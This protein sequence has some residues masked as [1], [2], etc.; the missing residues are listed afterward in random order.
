MT[1]MS[2]VFFMFLLVGA[3]LVWYVA[4]KEGTAWKMMMAGIIIGS[5]VLTRPIGPYLIPI[6]LAAGLSSLWH[7]QGARRATL[8]SAGFLFGAALVCIPWAFRNLNAHGQLAISGVGTQTLSGFNLAY[9]VAEGADIERSQAASVPNDRGNILQ[10]FIWV[11]QNYPG[12]LLKVNL[13]GIA[14]TVGGSE[15][16]SWIQMI[17]GSKKASLGLLS[18]LREHRWRDFILRLGHLTE[19]P[20]NLVVLSILVL[21]IG[22]SFILLTFAFLGI[23]RQWIVRDM[24]AAFFAL[25]VT[26]AYLI[27]APLAAGQ[28]RFRVPAEPFLAMLAGNGWLGLERRLPGSRRREPVV[29]A[30]SEEPD[31]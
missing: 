14:R 7:R 15:I 27:L 22:H 18:A 19:G 16:A 30:S 5:A 9:A 24:D 21:S 8:L 4:V 20:A 26:A 13:M 17:D 29:T 23:C 31:G 6:W 1:V 11:V 25:V 12:P 3:L 10:R 2:E 28:A